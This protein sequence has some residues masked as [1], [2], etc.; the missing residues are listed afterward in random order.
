[1]DRDRLRPT[2][3]ERDTPA[4]RGPCCA[5]SSA[6]RRAGPRRRSRTAGDAAARTG[7]VEQEVGRLHITMDDPR[8]VN[9]GQ[10]M[11]KLIQQN[12]DV[13]R[14]KRTVI[15]EQSRDRPTTH[16]IH[17]E[18][19]LVVIGCPPMRSDNVRMLDPQRLLPDEPQQRQPHRAAPAPSPPRTPT[20]EDPTPARPTPS[21]RSPSG[22]SADTAPQAPPPA[23]NLP[24]QR[25]PPPNQPRAE[26][27]SGRH[28]PRQSVLGRAPT[29]AG[30]SRWI[31]RRSA[32]RP[33]A[34]RRWTADGGGRRRPWW[35]GGWPRSGEHGPDHLA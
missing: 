16:Q 12:R 13:R 20:A 4:Y 18:H 28:E 9:C 3:Q 17:R 35:G 22:R 1:M 24:P 19:D 15:P 8:G 26:R 6:A 23:K 29:P 31:G 25:S 2:V 27:A 7:G 11:Q 10:T 5:G 32:R 33:S 34:A 30:A 21:R 14:R